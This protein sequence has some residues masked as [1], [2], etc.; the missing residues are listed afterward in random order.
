[1][2]LSVLLVLPVREGDN[3]TRF[4]IVDDEFTLDR[5]YATK[6]CEALVAANLNLK[7]DCPLGVRLDSCILNFL[8]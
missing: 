8:S 6:F 1:M 4:S 7:W 3:M 2:G 5:K